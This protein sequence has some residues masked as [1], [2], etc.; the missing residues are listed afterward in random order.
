MSPWSE[1]IR[2]KGFLRYLEYNMDKKYQIFISSTYKDLKPARNEVTQTIL[3]MGHFPIGMEMFGASNDEQ[4]KLITEAIDSSDYYLIIMGK[5]FG[6]EVPGEGISYTQKEFRYAKSKN[7]PVLAFIIDDEAK[8][9]KTYKETDI[10][11]IK[12]LNDFRKELESGRTVVYWKNKYDLAQHVAISL[13]KEMKRCPRP[14]WR[15]MSEIFEENNGIKSSNS[16]AILL[17][18]NTGNSILHPTI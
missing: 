11:R 13:E 9:A 1:K 6:S 2:K 18:I 7:I 8:V 3:S 4:W 14:G 17:P 10:D 16:D 15:R 5:T 12:K